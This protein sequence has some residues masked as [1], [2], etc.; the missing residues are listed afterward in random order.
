MVQSLLYWCGLYERLKKDALCL[1]IEVTK[2]NG[3]VAV[4]GLY[5]PREG[6]IECE[7][8]VKGRNLTYENLRKTFGGCKILV[9]YNGI[10]FDIPKIRAEF[11]GAIPENIPVIDLYRFARKV[12]MNTNLKVLENTI[13]IERLEDYQKKR[14]VAIRLW[15]RFTEYNDAQ[16]L[17]MLLEYNRQD[18]VNLYPIAEKIVAIVCERAEKEKFGAGRDSCLSVS[19]SS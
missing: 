12:G 15:K 10:N 5:K 3:Q 4:V 11:P 8:F 6:L 9:T 7:S 2:F 19:I 16:A 14:N 1:D 18:T 13:G 17:S